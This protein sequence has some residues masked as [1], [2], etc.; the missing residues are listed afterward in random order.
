MEKRKA[1]KLEFFSKFGNKLSQN[2]ENVS[3]F[4][5]APQNHSIKNEKIAKVNERKFEME[6]KLKQNRLYEVHKHDINQIMKKIEQTNLKEKQEREN[7]ELSWLSLI[8]LVINFNEIFFVFR[9]KGEF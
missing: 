4:T 7:F 8:S 1:K 2:I 9:V 3:R 6:V 5:S